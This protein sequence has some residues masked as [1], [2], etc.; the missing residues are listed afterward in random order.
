VRQQVCK[1]FVQAKD[2][3]A[4]RVLVAAVYSA[5]WRGAAPGHSRRLET[6]RLALRHGNLREESRV[7]YH[8]SSA[9]LVYRCWPPWLINIS[10]LGRRLAAY[11]CTT[12]AHCAGASGRAVKNIH[13]RWFGGGLSA[14]VTEQRINTLKG[15]FTRGCTLPAPLAWAERLLSACCLCMLTWRR[16]RRKAVHSGGHAAHVGGWLIW[17]DCLCLTEGQEEELCRLN[18]QVAMHGSALLNSPAFFPHLLNYSTLLIQL[19]LL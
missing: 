18:T 15:G 2:S 4:G 13:V 14:A 17:E 9:G 3:L 19:F 7:A 10:P 8:I 1:L 5:R 16:N 12:L 6:C 11:P